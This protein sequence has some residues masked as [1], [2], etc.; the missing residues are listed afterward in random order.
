MKHSTG[1]ALCLAVIVLTGMVTASVGLLLFKQ[2]DV[3]ALQQRIVDL[4]KENRSLRARLESITL[5]EH[6]QIPGE[7]GAP[8]RP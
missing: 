4:R 6:A 3:A 1:F 8:P 2:Q 7:S 5:A